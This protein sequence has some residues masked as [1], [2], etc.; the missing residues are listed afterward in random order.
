[1]GDDTTVD[2]FN[3]DI[4]MVLNAYARYSVSIHSTYR[5]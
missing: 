5:T 2:I 4:E 3:I 1:M